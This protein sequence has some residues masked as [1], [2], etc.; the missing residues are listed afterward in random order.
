[1]Q[2]PALAALRRSAPAAQITALGA[3]PAI[4]L[5]QEREIVDQTVAYQQWGI[6]HLWDHGAAD[7]AGLL[8]LWFAEMAFDIVLG[9]VH[10]PEPVWAAIARTG[11]PVRE[12]DEAVLN[13]ALAAGASA[14]AA[15]NRAAVRGWGLDSVREPDPAIRLSASE[16]DFARTVL[17]DARPVALC[18]VASSVLKR[19]P[20]DRF[21]WLAD[22]V[23]ECTGRRVLLFGTGEDAALNAVLVAMR[24]RAHALVARDLHL[25]DVAA[26]LS[27]CAML[28]STDTGL[29]HVAAAVGTVVLAIFGPTSPGVYLPPGE[30]AGFGGD[31]DCEHRARG[32]NPPGCWQSDRC[33][34]AVQKCIEAVQ[35]DVVLALL[36]QRLNASRG[37]TS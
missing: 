10:A 36:E 17:G 33:L 4:E 9:A 16:L 13:A 32:L 29:M 26:L 28:V 20:E 25:R 12:I 18:P 3:Q 15:F 37:T 34:I 19:W 7:T 35:A 5:L 11:L 8:D 21:A 6:R 22:S 14:A 30:N 31:V 23:I 27:R 24:R 2:L 1:M